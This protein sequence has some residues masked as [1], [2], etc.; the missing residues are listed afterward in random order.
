M[1]ELVIT[2][3]WRYPVKSMAGNPVATLRFDNIGPEEDRRWL[4]VNSKGEFLSQRRMPELG[5][6]RAVLLGQTLT[7]HAPGAEQMSLTP[8]DCTRR[9]VV[10]IWAD[11]VSA[12][13]A[14]R[15]VNQWLSERLGD[16]V[17]LVRYNTENPRVM[18]PDYASGHV[19]FADGF[20]LLVCHQDS[21]HKLNDQAPVAMEM[22]RF[23]P[24]VVVSGGQPWEEHDWAELTNERHRLA[25]VKPCER[26]AVITLKPGTTER[27]PQALKH[28]VSQSSRNGKPVFGINAVA[29]SRDN[30]LLLGE[31]LQAAVTTSVPTD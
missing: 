9:V 5:L 1:T 18:N 13:L 31:V 30:P 6:F 16:K 22:E 7:L 11:K 12:W 19:G 21:L 26:C 8:A 24:N 28:L 17:F 10:T 2:E 4:V 23:R 25:M 27:A 20:P 14:P 15:S 29:L 3:L